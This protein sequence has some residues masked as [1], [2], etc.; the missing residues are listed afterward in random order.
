MRVQ[1]ISA[2]MGSLLATGNLLISGCDSPPTKPPTSK[3]AAK[4][5]AA[6]GV[7]FNVTPDILRA[8]DPARIV[9]VAWNAAAA[10][11]STV[12][13]FV[14]REDGGENLFA[15]LGAVGSVDTGPW[16]GAKTVFILKDGNET[17]QLGSFVVGSES[18]N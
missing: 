14:V 18:C 11:V 8:C 1:M 15:F 17:K 9:K 5:E 2:V 16:V 7:S 3:S 13:I 12:K 10:G 6:P 4:S